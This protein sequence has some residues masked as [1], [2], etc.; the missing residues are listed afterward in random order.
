MFNKKTIKDIELQNKIVLLRT[1]Y[2]V[3]LKQLKDG[4]DVVAND[5]R[6]R[7]SLDTINYLL[8]QNV[9]KIII[10]SHLG[11]PRSVEGLSDVSE[12]ERA[13]N[14]TRKYSLRPAFNR[15]T[16]LMAEQY[17]D[18]VETFHNNFPMNF[19]SMPI[20]ARTRYTMPI[21]QANDN[22]KIEMLE[23]LRFSIDE[24]KNSSELAEALLQVSGADVFVQDGFG[25]VHRAHAS[26]DAITKFVPSVAGLLLEKEVMTIQQAFMDPKR[27][28]VAVMGGAKVG[29][30]LP[31]I[32]RFIEQADK[33]LVSGALA[34]TILCHKGYNMAK[35]RVESG[36][37]DI[38]DDIYRAAGQKTNN[39]DNFIILPKDVGVADEFLSSSQRH[40]KADRKSVV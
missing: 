4:S 3:P 24:K 19:H 22:Y 38:I 1:D 15:L 6:I 12:L 18:D 35:S 8:A 5:F 20:F 36:Q 21:N 23:N 16:E 9:K 25:V 17:G 27:P 32:N 28:F 37:A 2:N 29:D 11:R 33:I 14:G 10:I 31:L 40:N 13:E 39:I 7:S 30:K 26:T 34:N